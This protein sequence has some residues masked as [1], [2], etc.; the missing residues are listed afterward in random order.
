MAFR[1]ANLT[2]HMITFNSAASC[3]L[4]DIYRSSS[5]EEILE[6]ASAAKHQTFAP[7]S[8]RCPRISWF[9]LRGVQP[10]QINTPDLTLDFTA[11]IGTA[12]HEIVQTRLEAA[13]GDK[14]LDVGEY[15]KKA[16]P[17][18]VFELEKKGHETQ[19]NL[20]DPYPVRFACGG[21]I[22]LDGEV[23]LLEIKS[24]EFSS[25]RDL[26]DIKPKHEVQV[27]CYASLLNVNRALVL[28]IDRQYGEIKCFERRIT[29]QDKT[30][31]FDSMDYVQGCVEA[32]I[33]PDGLPVGDLDCREN[34]CP[35]WRKCKEWGR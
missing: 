23:T 20:M 1:E 18:W 9:R 2:S 7:S 29:G 24:S 34:M 31:L 10:D 3:S 12:C 15:L 25:F 30:Q 5:Q 26:T 35:Y 28:Y 14:W 8:M 21:L 13:L 33:A 19:I 6:Q 27:K 17:E 11:K 16:R 32:C 4:I 22:D